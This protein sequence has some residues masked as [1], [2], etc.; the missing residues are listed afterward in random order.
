MCLHEGIFHETAFVELP[1]GKSKTRAVK[2]GIEVTTPR[3]K[4]FA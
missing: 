2:S 4:N 3:E 1:H